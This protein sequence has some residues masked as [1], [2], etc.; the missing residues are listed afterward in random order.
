VREGATILLPGTVYNYGPDA[1]PEIAADAPQNPVT[2]KGLI[3]KELELRLQASTQR[4]ARVIIVRAG[5]Y[6]GPS[7]GNSWFAQGLIKLGKPITR[8]TVPNAK[9]I[10]HQWAYLPDV[11]R[12]ALALLS[13]RETLPAFANFHMQGH[14]DADGTQMAEAIARVVVKHSGARPAITAFP[15]WLI[16]LSAPFVVTLREMMELRYLWR[17]PVRISNRHLVQTLGQEPHT[18]LDDAVEQTL[19]GLGFFRD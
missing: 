18:A 11:A 16:T 3:R 9:G 6:F 2:R 19:V 15:W 17:V 14:W 1:F 10:G 13:R 4:G 12:T 8:I 7:V 5:D